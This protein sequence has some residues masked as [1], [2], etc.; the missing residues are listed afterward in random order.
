MKLHALMHVSVWRRRFCMYV[1]KVLQLCMDRFGLVFV[2]IVLLFY[3]V[4]GLCGGL[5]GFTSYRRLVVSRLDLF[6]TKIALAFRFL[7]GLFLCPA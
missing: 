2:L 1:P 4:G 7:L 3:F 5:L 6:N